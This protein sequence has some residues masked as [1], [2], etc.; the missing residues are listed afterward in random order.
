MEYCSWLQTVLGCYTLASMENKQ[1][2]PQFRS[3]IRTTIEANLIKEW[4]PERTDGIQESRLLNVNIAREERS[5][6]LFRIVELSL[7]PELRQDDH[8]MA[9]TVQVMLL[10]EQKFDIIEHDHDCKKISKRH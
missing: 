8:S 4:E 6:D 2:Y 9:Y 3:T 5:G 7:P 1:L 10:H